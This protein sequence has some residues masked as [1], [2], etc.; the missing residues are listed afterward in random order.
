M[1]IIV[2]GEDDVRGAMVELT[3]VLRE[4]GEEAGRLLGV[5][6]T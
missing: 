6:V 2:R 3:E 5:A 1:C 4:R